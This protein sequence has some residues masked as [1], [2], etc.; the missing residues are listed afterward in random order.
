MA[1]GKYLKDHIAQ[2]CAIMVFLLTAISLCGQ[3]VN[4][5]GNSNYFTAFNWWVVYLWIFPFAFIGISAIK[6]I[7]QKRACLV[8]AFCYGYFTTT[9]QYM[10]FMLCALDDG[11]FERMLF[12]LAGT[13]VTIVAMFLVLI[14]WVYHIDHSDED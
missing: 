7:K 14:I 3:I 13:F 2:G 11:T 5:L 12:V 9:M 4:L 10:L 8:N 1:F 6:S